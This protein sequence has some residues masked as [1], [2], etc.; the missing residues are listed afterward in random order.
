MSTLIDHPFLLLF[1]SLITLCLCAWLGA[2]AFGKWL[3][4][5]HAARQELTLVLSAALTLL[6][7]IIGFTFSMAIS[8]YD[9]RKQYEQSEATAIETEYL[10]ADLLPAADAARLRLQLRAYLAQRIAFYRASD[11]ARARQI[12]E[13]TVK[14]QQQLWSGLQASAASR[15]N[16][17]TMLVVAGMNNVLAFRGDT[18]ALWWNRIPVAA[19]TLMGLIA[20]LCNGLLG[21]SARHLK[22][23]T[24]VLVLP[25]V[26]SIAFFMIADIDSPRGGVIH[27]SPRNLLSVAS[28]LGDWKLTAD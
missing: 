18:Q 6:G 3:P 27:V 4:H 25:L 10:R 1:V 19:W 5:E 7:L 13:Q 26:L 11:A 24:V 14:L 9:M 8:R 17:L 23:R 20:I 22:G 21:F 16:S 2:T 15:P 12:D 28:L